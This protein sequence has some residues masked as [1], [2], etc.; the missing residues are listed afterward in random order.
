M[1]KKRL[2]REMPQIEYYLDQLNKYIEQLKLM[3]YEMK[4][5]G[6]ARTLIPIQKNTEY[7]EVLKK[8]FMIF[9]I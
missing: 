1:K 7:I 3:S 5:N 8:K 9:I 6:L 2:G 4:L